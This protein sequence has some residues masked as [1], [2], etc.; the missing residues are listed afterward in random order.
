MQQSLTQILNMVCRA[1]TFA[2]GKGNLPTRRTINDGF[3]DFQYALACLN[4]N[5][6]TRGYKL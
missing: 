6:H 3:A 4:H 5:V 1:Y 2:Q